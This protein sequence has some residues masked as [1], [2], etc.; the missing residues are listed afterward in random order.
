M[1]GCFGVIKTIISSLLVL[2]LFFLVLIGI[3]LAAISQVL[4]D[5]ES[6]KSAV[7]EE[8]ILTS[9]FDT[10]ISVISQ[11]LPEGEAGTVISDDLTDPESD[12]RKEIEELIPIEQLEEEL[13][14]VI[15]AFYDW[16][17]G[18]VDEPEFAIQLTDDA[19][20]FGDLFYQQIEESIRSLP[21]CTTPL[22]EQNIENPLEAD[23]IPPDFDIDSIDELLGESED[24]A[25]FEDMLDSATI[26][27]DML[28]ITPETTENVQ[29]IFSI[30]EMLHIILAAV[31]IAIV[32]ILL[33]LIPKVSRSFTISGITT[34]IPSALLL[35]ASLSSDRVIQGT[36]DYTSQRLPYEMIEF[37]ETVF[38]FVQSAAELLFANI[39]TYSIIMTSIG[40][41]LLIL[42]IIFTIIYRRRE[43]A[44][45]PSIRRPNEDL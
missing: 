10:S 21:E 29:A 11:N 41:V 14:T 22:E 20:T 30:L 32:L 28:D 12:F 34:L 23:C 26:S 25:S 33:A 19:E 42:G 3:P 1:S 27:S 8:K 7:T 6:V 2:F 17:E 15:D 44:R 31:Y 9:V 36:Q 43:A 39:K 37:S 35:V 16:F 24:S 13:V 40:G 18:K 45:S 38:V 5:R 4:V